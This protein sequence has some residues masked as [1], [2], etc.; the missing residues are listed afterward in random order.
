M[1]NSQILETLLSFLTFA[2]LFEMLWIF[3]IQVGALPRGA[4][5]EIEAVA[6]VGKITNIQ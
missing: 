1:Y 3:M 6:V 5:I 2:V 4:R